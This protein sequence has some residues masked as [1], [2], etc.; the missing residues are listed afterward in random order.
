[1]PGVAAVE[2]AAAPCRT[3]WSRSTSSR[4]TA[5]STIEARRSS[6]A[7]RDLP[8]GPAERPGDR[9]SRP[10]SWTPSRASWITCRR[11]SRSSRS[12]TFVVLFL[13]TGSVV[14]PIKALVMNLLTLSAVFGILVL[15]FQDGR[16]EGLLGYTSQGAH[17]ADDAAA[18]VRGRVRALDRLRGV[19]LV[20]HQGGAR[21]RRQRL[22]GGRDRARA[23]GADRH[24]RGRLCSRSRSAPS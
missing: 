8:E 17:R 13:F 23:H 1:M 19:P 5:R 4:A 24:R 16:L 3:G 21:R 18:P 6:T 12:A 10:T 14:L 7:I 2:S 22:G 9:A 20:A 11:C 15:I